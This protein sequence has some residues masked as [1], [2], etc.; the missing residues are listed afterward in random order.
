MSTLL[1]DIAR[2]PGVPNEPD[3]PPGW[4]EGCETCLRRAKLILAHSV[5][6][7]TQHVS[8]ELV[9]NLEADTSANHCNITCKR[10][11]ICGEQNR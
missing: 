7:P 10:N 5:S 11:R 4:R 9:E 3:E 2:C 6:T 1:Y 8:A